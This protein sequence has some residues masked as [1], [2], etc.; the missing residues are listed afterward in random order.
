MT[1]LPPQRLRRGVRG[2]AVILACAALSAQVPQC[3]SMPAEPATTVVGEPYEAQLTLSAEPGRP[4]NRRILGTNLQWTERGDRLLL[5]GS[6]EFDPQVLDLIEAL[7][8]TVLRYP[9]GSQSDLYHWRAGMGG[10]ADRG[11]GEY[12]GDTSKREKVIFGTREFLRLADTLDA[13][14][15]ITVN[16][17]SG[18]PEEAAG[19]VRATNVT[20]ITTASGETLGPVRY[21]EIGNEPYLY[22]EERPDLEMKP[23][24]YAERASRIMRAMRAV[25]PDIQLGLPLRNDT[26]GGF[27]IPQQY[28][29]FVDTVLTRIRVPF[30]FVSLH[31]AY[32]PF[33][34]QRDT[35][36]SD[37]D[38]FRA[39]MSASRIVE[40]DLAATRRQ[41]DR[42]FPDRDIGIAVTEYSPLFTVSGRWDAYL[43][44]LGGALYVADLLRVFAQTEG[45]LM[46]NHWSLLNNWR[47]GALS[48]Q[49]PRSSR[50]EPTPIYQVLW[51]FG[52]VLRGRMLPVGIDAP[53][54]DSPLVGLVPAFEGTRSVEAIATREGGV[55]RVLVINKDPSRPLDLYV[56]N[57]APGATRT[58]A[59]ILGGSSAFG[60]SNSREEVR[61]ED[62]EP[63]PSPGEAIRVP[64][65]SLG[66][67]EYG[68]GR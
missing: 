20:G 12:F 16:V 11:E 41:L 29:G 27:M 1:R 61:W 3:P 56:T 13:V 40:D 55:V 50:V 38:L 44:T 35:Q 68:P 53:S 8:P 32:F 51:A 65:H 2:P 66:W 15:V 33:V 47:F 10:L 34:W 58:S 36:Y 23:A 59:R 45:L 6:L 48:N 31:D 54:F 57:E 24:A 18:T 60:S 62:V 49:L 37:D 17:A 46:A 26:I 28:A 5:P 7:G 21:W 9:G 43:N 63:L 25:D 39:L 22:Q 67:I 4:V 30:E 19:W 52:Q 64:P 14:P 42:Y